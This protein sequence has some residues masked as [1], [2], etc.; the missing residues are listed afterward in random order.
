M[1]SVHQREKEKKEMEKR[2][3][4]KQLREKKEQKRGKK[5]TLKLECLERTLVTLLGLLHSVS[6]SPSGRIE[7]ESPPYREMIL[8]KRNGSYRHKSTESLGT[9]D[10]SYRHKS[11]ESLRRGMLIIDTSLPKASVHLF[12]Y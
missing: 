5:L 8:G 2:G 3:K 7:G 4:R 12:I 6:L 9:R 11:T 1:E 10:G